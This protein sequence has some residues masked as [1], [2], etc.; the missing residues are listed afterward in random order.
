M[1]MY[2]LVKAGRAKAVVDTAAFGAK[3]LV[4]D[5]VH[6]RTRRREKNFM[7]DGSKFNSAPKRNESQ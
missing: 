1:L 5:R 2:V 6:A 7:V 4:I 3:A